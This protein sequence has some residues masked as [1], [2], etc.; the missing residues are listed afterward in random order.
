MVSNFEFCHFY[1]IYSVIYVFFCF[2]DKSTI[3]FMDEKIGEW[4]MQ[5]FWVPSFLTL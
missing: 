2:I 4:K 5:L 3:F 1:V